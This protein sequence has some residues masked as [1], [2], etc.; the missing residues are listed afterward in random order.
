MTLV[1]VGHLSRMKDAL[2]QLRKANTRQ[3][4]VVNSSTCRI[5]KASADYCITAC[6]PELFII[7]GDFE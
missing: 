5:V 3:S 2:P 1:A 6:S 4:I 7:E